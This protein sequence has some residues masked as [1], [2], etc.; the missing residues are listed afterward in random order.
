ME[1]IKYYV[2]KPA[3]KRKLLV[4]VLGPAAASGIGVFVFESLPA[5]EALLF[6]DAFTV[7]GLTFGLAFLRLYSEIENT[8]NI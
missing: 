7:M 3:V 5:G 4:N 6:I 1:V 2:S 8:G